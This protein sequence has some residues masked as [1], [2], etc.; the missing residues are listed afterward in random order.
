MMAIHPLYSPLGPDTIV[1]E[2]CRI[3]RLAGRT[4]Y[5]AVRRET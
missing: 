2:K 5:R 4:R 1:A 3:A